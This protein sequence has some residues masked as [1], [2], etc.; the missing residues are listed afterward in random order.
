MAKVLYFILTFL[1]SALSVFGIRST[2]QQPDYRVIAHLTNAIEIRAY[3]PITVVETS[4]R[5]GDGQAFS[6]L[7]DYITGANTGDHLIKM[8]VPVEQ[9]GGAWSDSGSSGA[10]LMRFFLPPKIAADAPPP[11]DPRVRVVNLLPRTIAAIRFSG[12]IDHQNLA[13][14]SKVLRD[15]LAKAG[16]KTDGAPFFLGY[17]PP[18]TIPALRRNEVAIG[19]EP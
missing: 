3:G 15:T 5:E 10:T 12:S 19:V 14:H 11:K 7:F 13:S 4:A 2:Q 9:S 1:E 6:R 16:R 8:T 18:F 17:D